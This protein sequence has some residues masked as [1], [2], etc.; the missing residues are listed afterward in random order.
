MLLF[1]IVYLIGVICSYLVF[2]TYVRYEGMG[3]YQSDR[4]FNIFFSVIGSW[5][6]FLVSFIAYIICKIQDDFE[7][8]PVKW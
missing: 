5:F 3:Y 1:I 6:T 7:D 8:N 4:I 2:R